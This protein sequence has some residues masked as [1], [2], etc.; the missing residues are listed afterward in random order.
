MEDGLEQERGQREQQGG[1]APPRRQVKQTW[2][3]QASVEGGWVGEEPTGPETEGTCWWS[4]ATKGQGAGSVPR[5]PSGT[6]TGETESP[7]AKTDTD[8]DGREGEGERGQGLRRR[9]LEG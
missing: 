6:E 1:W 4:L 8:P 2:A 3:P 5:S 7:S 9:A